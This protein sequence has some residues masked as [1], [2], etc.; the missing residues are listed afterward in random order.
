MNVKQI[1]EKNVCCI[2]RG[3]YNNY[4]KQWVSIKGL[5]LAKHNHK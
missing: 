1:K 4:S 3:I 5:K 2:Y